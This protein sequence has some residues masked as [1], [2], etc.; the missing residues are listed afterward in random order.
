[1]LCSFNNSRCRPHACQ[2]IIQLS[3][4]TL[5][6]CDYCVYIRLSIRNVKIHGMFLVKNADF[7]AESKFLKV[8]VVY[9]IIIY[10]KPTTF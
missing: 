2:L 5:P 1:M 3:Q 7:D 4:S 9:Y 6:I 10:D 8:F